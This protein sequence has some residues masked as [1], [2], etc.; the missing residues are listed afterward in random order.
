MNDSS[1]KTRNEFKGNISS[2]KIEFN[3]IKQEIKILENKINLN[4]IGNKKIEM[5]LMLVETTELR[6]MA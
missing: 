4:I 5:S 2:Q 3:K 1:G 6:K